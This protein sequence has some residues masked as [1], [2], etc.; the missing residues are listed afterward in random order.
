[1]KHIL[2]ALRVT[3]SGSDMYVSLKDG[4]NTYFKIKIKDVLKQ[5][6]HK[7]IKQAASEL[8]KTWDSGTDAVSSP[9]KGMAGHY[10]E[11]LG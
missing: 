9:V 4:K 5:D 2:K 3:A 10:L 7:G 11:L 8:A 1:M 6:F